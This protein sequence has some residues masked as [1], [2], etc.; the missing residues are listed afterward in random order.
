[1]RVRRGAATLALSGLALM[2]AAC[3]WAQDGDPLADGNVLYRSGDFE[4]AAQAYEQALEAGY[5]GPRT[6][7]N[8]GNAL[9]RSSRLGEAIAHFLAASQMAPRDADI[10]ANLARALNQRPQ[11]P[12]APP[13][14]WLHAAADAMVGYF[15][16]GELASTAAALYWLAAAVVIMHLARLRPPRS[17][18]RAAIVLGAL[19]LV[20]SVLAMGR[21]WSYH[22]P[23]R[24]V[25]AV[26]STGI[27]TG[28]GESFEVAQTATEGWLLHVTA[29]DTG[30]L[31][32]HAEGGARGWLPSSAIVRV[33][34]AGGEERDGAD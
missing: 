27:R 17:L 16:L 31:R 26:E 20:L 8:L 11:G 34:A 4:G 10:R 33:S 23:A 15:T 2:L 7:Y 30:W 14:S 21:W 25:V 9:Y 12:P 22:R 32:V 18:R 24:A 5:D 1:M 6:H 19:A 13:P 29:D 28:P 3:T